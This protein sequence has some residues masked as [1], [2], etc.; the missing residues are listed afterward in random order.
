MLL[1]DRMRPM[2]TLNYSL[3]RYVEYIRQIFIWESTVQLVSVG[4][5]RLAPK[6]RGVIPTNVQLWLKLPTVDGKK[7][8]EREDKI[9]ELAIQYVQNGSCPPGLSRD[10][11]WA[12]WIRVTTVVCDKGCLYKEN[13]TKWRLSQ[14]MSVNGYWLQS[15]S[16]FSKT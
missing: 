3:N 8:V 1:I 4:S 10:K 6:T 2:V 12:R 5:F 9:L 16:R 7:T 11:K 13:S 14:Q 15:R